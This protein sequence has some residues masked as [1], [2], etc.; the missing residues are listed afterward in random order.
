MSNTNANDPGGTAT[1]PQILARLILLQQGNDL[2]DPRSMEASED[3]LRVEIR[4]RDRAAFDAWLAAL[5]GRQENVQSGARSRGDVLYWVLLWEWHGQWR[6]SVELAEAAPAPP[7][8][9]DADTVAGL[10]DIAGPAE[11]ASA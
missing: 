5:G 10:E 2:P 9:L 7:G 11:A 4:V 6:V 3:H 1:V 8:K